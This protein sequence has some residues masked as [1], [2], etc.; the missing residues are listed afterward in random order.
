[1]PITL[2]KGSLIRIEA[3]LHEDTELQYIGHLA[4]R[5]SW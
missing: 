5:H 1:M 4:R 3:A 2:G